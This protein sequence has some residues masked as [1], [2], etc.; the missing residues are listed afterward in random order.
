MRFMLGQVMACSQVGAKPLPKPNG[1]FS[2]IEP[3]FIE[4][5]MQYIGFD[6]Y[7]AIQVVVYNYLSICFLGIYI[8]ISNISN[9][10]SSV[11]ETAFE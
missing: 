8:Y 1:E 11:T 2:S 9:V 3:Y 6:Q 4:Q 5:S 7:N 10:R